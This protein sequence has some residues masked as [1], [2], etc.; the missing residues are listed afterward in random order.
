MGL[1]RT[2]HLAWSSEE[3]YFSRQSVGR[4]IPGSKNNS[5]RCDDRELTWCMVSHP[6]GWEPGLMAEKLLKTKMGR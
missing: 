3:E 2:G 6:R 1:Q 4:S 5:G